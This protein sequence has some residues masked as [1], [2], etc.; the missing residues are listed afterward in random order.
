MMTERKMHMSTIIKIKNL[1]QYY[2]RKQAL[3]D[4]N[5]TIEKIGRASCRERVCTDV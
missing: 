1:N 4:I 2:G 5:L 3:R